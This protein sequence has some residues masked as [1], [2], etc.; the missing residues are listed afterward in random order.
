M[1]IAVSFIAV[2][3]VF[4]SLA[5]VAAPLPLW[6]L[7]L[8]LGSI[9]V[10]DY[11]GSDRRRNFLL[12][13]PHIIYRG[14]FL[15]IDRDNIKGLLFSSERLAL[16]LSASAAPPVESDKNQARAG[17]E[18]LNPV[19]EIGV[20]PEILL[21][22]DKGGRAIFLKLP[23]RKVIATDLSEFSDAGWTF[24]PYL[25]YLDRRFLGSWNFSASIGPSFATS[26]YHEYYY[27][28][29]PSQATAIR[30]VFDAPAGYSGSRLTLILDRRLEPHL[31]LGGFLRYDYLGGASFADSPLVRQ[32]HSLMGG[33]AFT[34]FFARS[35]ILQ[36]RAGT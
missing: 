22:G 36:S 35:R 21:T 14:V 10:P 15:E 34:W 17:M 30:P 19:L 13:F 9:S 25:E 11:R 32:D 27:G 33:L 20:S 24:S 8:G 4:R 26:P 18:D 12:P 2:L 29:D 7:G 3:L 28:V 16:N 23:V 6:E 31:W 5:A 1:R